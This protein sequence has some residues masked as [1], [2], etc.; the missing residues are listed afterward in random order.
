MHVDVDDGLYILAAGVCAADGCDLIR[1][2]LRI[3]RRR[4]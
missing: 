1:D 2:A 4:R 3:T